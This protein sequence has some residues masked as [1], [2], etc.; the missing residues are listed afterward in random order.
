M[1]LRA[2]WASSVFNG[3]IKMEE[4]MLIQVVDI[5]K[6]EGLLNVL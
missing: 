5:E 3:S 4:L 1:L 6:G 2:S